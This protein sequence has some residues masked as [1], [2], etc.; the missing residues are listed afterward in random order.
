LIGSWEK[1]NLAQMLAYR[2]NFCQKNPG[3]IT[4]IN[5]FFFKQWGGVH[6]EK[7]GRLLE[8][9]TYDGMSNQFSMNN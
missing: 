6:N 9:K 7:N 8:G 3:S 5:I 4:G 2:I 1:A